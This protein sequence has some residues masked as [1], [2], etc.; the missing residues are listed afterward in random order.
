MRSDSHSAEASEPDADRAPRRFLAVAVL[1]VNVWL[2]LPAL[3]VSLLMG[4]GLF[5]DV[6]RAELRVAAFALFFVAIAIAVVSAAWFVSI[7][8]SIARRNA[9]RKTPAR[10]R[11][12]DAAR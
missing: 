10:C 7:V 9:N 3:A 11:T 12:S 4:A 8:R 2:V 6:G 5:A 1:L